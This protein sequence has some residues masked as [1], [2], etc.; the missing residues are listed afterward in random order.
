MSNPAKFV[1]V[2]GL[3]LMVPTPARDYWR[4]KGTLPDGRT[5]D[6]TGGRTIEDARAKAQAAIARV[7]EVQRP[8][9][10]RHT[11][12]R[13]VKVLREYVNPA[14]HDNWGRGGGSRNASTVKSMLWNHV[15]PVLGN[16]TCE[17]LTPSDF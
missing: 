3:T 8:G 11:N 2:D 6:T 17:S 16:R 10:A 9:A 14:N 12:V 1:K 4:I 15:L 5:I 7:G 13:Y